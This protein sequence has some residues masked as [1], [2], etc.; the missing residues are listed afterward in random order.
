L[1]ARPRIEALAPQALRQALI[2]G[3]NSGPDGTLNIP[4]LIREARRKV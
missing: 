4:E 1:S 2:D 3:E